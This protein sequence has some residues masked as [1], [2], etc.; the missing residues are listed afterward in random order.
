[1]AIYSRFKSGLRK[2]HDRLFSGAF[3][4][5]LGRGKIDDEFLEG[6]EES[7]LACDVG[8]SATGELIER[9]GELARA[10]KGLGNLE[11][12]EELKREL[13][14]IMGGAARGLRTASQLPTVILV[15][16]VNGT[17]KTTTIAKLASIL[18]NDGRKVILAA[19]DTF[20]AAAIEQL[21]H[22]GDVAGAQV[23]KHQHGA[24]PAAIAYDAVEAAG[25]RGVDYVIIDTAGRLHTK[26]NL[27]EELK[28]ISRVVAKRVPDAPH[29]TLLVVD[30]TTGQNALEQAKIFNSALGLTGIILTKLDGTARG[31]IVVSIQKELSI[32]VKFVGLGE[33]ID[34]LQPFSAVEFVEALFE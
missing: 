34:D 2:T 28:K 14:N 33:G 22:W 12:T 7:L 24:D 17:G 25:A 6:L 15:V 26:T 29:E 19:C 31:G 18:K 27:M 5:L 32:P 21:E 11:L 3:G 8:V 20:R 4:A 9:L 1:M 13:V 30:G 16:G 23:I 10:E